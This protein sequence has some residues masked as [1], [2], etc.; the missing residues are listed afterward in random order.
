MG[1][2]HRHGEA[3]PV[4]LEADLITREINIRLTIIANLK[5]DLTELGD[6]IHRLESG[7]ADMTHSGNDLKAAVPTLLDQATN[8]VKLAHQVTEEFSRRV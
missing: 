5:Q 2:R 4:R 3:D 7:N 1:G 6:R 8:M